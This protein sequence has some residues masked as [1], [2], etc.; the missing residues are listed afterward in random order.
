MKGKSYA[1]I[2][3]IIDPVSVFFSAQTIWSVGSQGGIFD[4]LLTLKNFL[5]L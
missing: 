1:C 5:N 2:I 3:I 4:S